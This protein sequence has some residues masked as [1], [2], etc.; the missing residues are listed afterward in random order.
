[1]W[2]FAKWIAHKNVFI[3]LLIW[4]GNMKNHRLYLNCNF[5]LIFLVLYLSQKI[6]VR[7]R[8]IFFAFIFVWSV[9]CIMIKICV[10][11]ILYCIFFPDKQIISVEFQFICVKSHIIVKSVNLWVFFFC[12]FRC[13]IQL[14]NL[15]DNG[16]KHTKRNTSVFILKVIM[17]YVFKHNQNHYIIPG[18]VSNYI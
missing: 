10:N 14:L 16:Y 5:N 6:C 18:G 3:Y 17:K 15:P 13:K 4:R 2:F 12:K 8:N 7:E 9:Q 1:M 11:Y